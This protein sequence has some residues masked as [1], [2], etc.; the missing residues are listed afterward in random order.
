MQLRSLIKEALEG[1][2][3]GNTIKVN[4]IVEIDAEDLIN[5]AMTDNSSTVF[6]QEA[7]AAQLDV[8][9]R[10]MNFED[11][12]MQEFTNV[13]GTPVAVRSVVVDGV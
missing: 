12:L 4:I 5:D 8:V 13:D 11:Q 9:L 3:G 1:E 6:P 2:P 10:G 7:V